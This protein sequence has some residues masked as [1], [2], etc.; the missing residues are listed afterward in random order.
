MASS[1]DTTK[2]CTKCGQEFPA[3]T[4]YFSPNRK[5]KDG[6]QARCKSC[7]AEWQREY[8]KSHPEAVRA[9]EANR[10]KEK[11][12]QQSRD[13][14]QR[15]AEARRDYRRE[16]YQIH[17]E[18][19]LEY[20]CEYRKNNREK[21]RI[22][23]RNWRSKNRD[24]YLEYK[25]KY[26]L[27]NPDV[28]RNARKRYENNHPKRYRLIKRLSSMRRRAIKRN[29]GGNFTE[30]DV[31]LQVESQ[32][33]LCWWCGEPLGNE[34]HIDHRIPLSKGGSNDAR[35]IVITHPKCNLSKSDK[36]PWEYNGR[37]L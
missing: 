4:E 35:N 23:H 33:G 6:L 5:V 37:L 26:R 7:C 20:Q 9:V 22:L 1:N 24:H 15:N 19:I 8:R 34:Y 18:E 13:Y 36:M 16:Y 27:S 11:R 2:R 31:K 10:D 21:R 30:Q 29:T 32:R 17:T 12:R 28:H 14:Y 25:R 3:T